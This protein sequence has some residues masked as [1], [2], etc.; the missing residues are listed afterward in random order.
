[1]QE[2]IKKLL[3][4]MHFMGS[5]A[6]NCMSLLQTAF[7]YNSSKPLKD[8]SEIVQSIIKMEGELTKKITELARTTPDLKPYVSIPVHFLRI[9]E[10][11]KKLSELIDQKIKDNILFSDKAISEITFLLERLIDIL[12]PSSDI[13]LAKNIILKKYVEESESDIIKRATEYATLHEDRLIEGSC[14]PV[15][16]SIYIHMLDAIK[17]I[18]WHAKEIAVKVVG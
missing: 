8:C 5:N 13:I 1:M 7:I 16:S 12:R 18:S 4:E 9:G 15:A 14:L 17:N 3:K 2:E 10:N 6:E 11:I